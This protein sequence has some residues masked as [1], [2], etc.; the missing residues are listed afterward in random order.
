MYN[1]R[2]MKGAE[3]GSEVGFYQGCFYVWNQMLQN[4]AQ[5]QKIKY[6]LFSVVATRGSLSQ[7]HAC[8]NYSPVASSRVVRS[9]RA[10]KSIISFGALLDAFELK[11][12]IAF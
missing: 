6:V 10:S 5:R 11:V 3:I 12:R 2:I 7:W 4:E 8:G 9:D 1:Y